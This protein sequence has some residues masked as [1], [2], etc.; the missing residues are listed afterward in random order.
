LS[1]YQHHFAL[2]LPLPVILSGAKNPRILPLPLLL[3]LS[4]FLFLSFLNRHSAAKRRN[5]LFPSISMS[6]PKNADPALGGLKV[7]A[8]LAWGNA[9]GH[10]R[11]TLSGLK[12]R[13]KCLIRNSQ[14]HESKSFSI[15]NIFLSPFSAQKTHVK[16][17][18]HL[19]PSNKR[20]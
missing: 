19:N 7:R 12:A 8:T 9:P 3:S 20:K 4:L 5:L 2:P 6:S 15:E 18:N 11:L 17:Q 1:K 10:N 16:P 14:L 13:A